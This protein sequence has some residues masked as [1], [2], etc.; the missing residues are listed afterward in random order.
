MPPGFLVFIGSSG[1]SHVAVVV[2]SW[3]PRRHE[4]LGIGRHGSLEELASAVSESLPDAHLTFYTPEDTGRVG[5]Q[6]LSLTH[7]M[8]AHAHRLASATPT[9]FEAI[10]RNTKITDRVF[11]EASDYSS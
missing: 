2:F 6:T 10:A 8:M 1:E 7:P 3:E 4:L 9:A 11:S 5:W